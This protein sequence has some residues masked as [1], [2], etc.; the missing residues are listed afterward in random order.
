L[1]STCSSSTEVVTVEEE[2]LAGAF[3]ELLDL[4]ELL[5]DPQADNP[6]A[7]NARIGSNV[8]VFIEVITPFFLGSFEV[9]SQSTS[10]VAPLNLCHCVLCVYPL[11][12]E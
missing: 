12:F 2:E 5:L 7:A 9:L 10:D 11:I 6:K 1:K 8:F 3:E 4:T